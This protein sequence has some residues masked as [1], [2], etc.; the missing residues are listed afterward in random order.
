MSDIKHIPPFYLLLIFG[1][2]ASVFIF[3]FVL[4]VWNRW[5]LEQNRREL[6]RNRRNDL[7]DAKARAQRWIDRLGS[8]IMMAAPEGKEAK[9]LVGLASQRH[10]GALG[11]INSAQTVAQA[12]VAQDVAL[13]GLYY[14]RDARTL[15]GELEGPPLPELGS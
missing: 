1:L 11:Q 2:V 6:E 4:Q 5:T 14:M 3:K 9:Q 7:L 10:A 12:T 13:E 15:M 8:E